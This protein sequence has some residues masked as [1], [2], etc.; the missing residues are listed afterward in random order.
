MRNNHVMQRGILGTPEIKRKTALHLALALAG[1][2]SVNGAIA[3]V[4]THTPQPKSFNIDMTNDC[5]G[6]GTRVVQGTY[7]A[8]TGALSVTTTL[9]ACVVR[10]GDK[11]DGTTSTA[12]TLL[13]TE[14]GYEIDIT[15]SVDTTIERSDL[16]KVERSC[17]VTKKG[18]YTTV[19]Q[20][21]VGTTARTNCSVTGQVLEHESLVEHL[22][23]PAYGM[24]EGGGLDMGSRMIPPQPGEDRIPFRFDVPRM[25]GMGFMGGMGGGGHE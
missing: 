10:N 8:D 25:N 12:G 1:L 19:N 4:I 3:Q 15:A 7:D 18:T 20:T 5:A 22:L 24:A 21:F 23:R 13:A 11:F 2:V 9:T 17:T 6:G 16:S 14:T